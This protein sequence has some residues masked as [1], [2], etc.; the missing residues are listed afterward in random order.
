MPGETSEDLLALYDGAS[1]NRRYWVAFAILS[2]I[3]V[4]EFFDFSVVAFLLAVVGPQWH[5]TYGQSALILY[6]G[7][8]GAIAGALIFGSLADA[9]GRKAQMVIG[10]FI[11]GIAA[12]L[13]GFVPDGAWQLFALLRF[14]VGLGLTAAVVPCLTIVV[15]L[16]PTRH[17]T[18]VTSFYVAFATAGGLLSSIT[19]AALL[20]AIGWRGMAMLGISVAA[21]GVL[22]LVFVPESVRW[23]TAKGRFAEARAEVAKQLGIPLRSVP[24]PTMMPAA[25]PRGRLSELLQQPRQFWETLI[26]WGGAATAAYGVYL[27][28]PTVISLLLKVP[29]PQAAKYF[30]WVAGA[31]IAGKI[32]VSFLAPVLG[33]RL[34]GVLWGFGGVAALATVGYCGSTLIGS[35]P[36]IVVA[37]AASSF[38][39]DGSFS[40][41]APYTVE[42][43]GVRMGARASGLGQAANG[44][45]KILGPLSLA[46]IAGTSNIVS[47]KATEGALVPA[48]LF[49]AIG[50]LLVGLSFA[51]LGR[52]T[53][54]RPMSLGED[55]PAAR[56]PVVFGAET[57]P[58][59]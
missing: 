39:I 7:G 31:G 32:I 3:T 4:L 19:S 45:G 46:L 34:L 54:G 20:A 15:E 43:Y 58:T 47:P 29:V 53:H 14:V 23:L 1:L 26:I 57:R 48:F 38:C 44:V 18:F 5:L 56:Q 22:A 30:I 52:E 12:A 9:W 37:L 33:R 50:M 10:T 35:V 55:E 42:S 13:I 17:R 24:L 21:V 28:G 49:L 59:S 16:T 41:L 40:N 6:S 11:C 2:A 27:W 36:L 8:L 51:I 25:V